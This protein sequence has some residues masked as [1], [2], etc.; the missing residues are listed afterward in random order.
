MQRFLISY[1]YYHKKL[2]IFSAVNIKVAIIFRDIPPCN[3]VD[4][5]FRRNVMPQSSSHPEYGSNTFL[6]SYIPKFRISM[7]FLSTFYIEDR[8]N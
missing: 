6:H 3:L 4:T 1:N 2:E 5:T 7:Q 8:G